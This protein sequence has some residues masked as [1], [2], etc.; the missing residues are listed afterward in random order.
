MNVTTD[1][2]GYKEYGDIDWESMRWDYENSKI[3]MKKLGAKYGTYPM[4]ISREAKKRKWIK[5]DPIKIA[6]DSYKS[7]LAVVNPNG[8]LNTVAVR[9]IQEIVEVLGD[10]YSPVD[11]PLVVMYA[12][13]YQRYLRLESIVDVEG[14][15]AI[16][17]KTGATYLSPTFVALQGVIS[18]M[19]KLGDKLGLSIAARS[20]IGMSLTPE[21]KTKSLFDLVVEISQDN[22]VD[23]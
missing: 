2:L 17:P 22:D 7:K 8:I 10:N 14:E 21:E 5:Y 15:V 12:K 16:S 23:V 4:Q 1:N 11:E 18:N 20:R 3:G 9:K 13:N 6:L 19:S